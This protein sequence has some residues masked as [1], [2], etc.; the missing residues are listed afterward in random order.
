MILTQKEADEWKFP[1]VVLFRPEMAP[2]SIYFF[3]VGEGPYPSS[4]EQFLC[5]FLQAVHRLMMTRLLIDDAV[6]ASAY[7]HI[8]IFRVWIPDISTISFIFFERMRLTQNW[9]LPYSL[10]YCGTW[11]ILSGNRTKFH[12][13][14]LDHETL[15]WHL[16]QFAW[17]IHVTRNGVVN[18]TNWNLPFLKN[19][20]S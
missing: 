20:S 10:S 9:M 15:F 6:F 8:F 3:L 18:T 14:C 2:D 1:L 12:L 17:K 16:K 11:I 7:L 19:S 5:S 4:L 13:N